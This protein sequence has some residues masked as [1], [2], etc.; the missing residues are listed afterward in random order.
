MNIGIIELIM[1]SALAFAAFSKN[2]A[3][4]ERNM[5]MIGMGV[6]FLII[7]LQGGGST[8]GTPLSVMMGGNNLTNLL[9]VGAVAYYLIHNKDVSSTQL[10]SF[11]PIM[12]GLLIYFFFS[13]ASSSSTF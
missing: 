8:P 11:R 4:D 6:L 12:I 7:F 3:K 2:I 1:L 5:L 10:R 13:A 9:I